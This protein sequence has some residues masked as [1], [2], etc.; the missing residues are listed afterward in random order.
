V[1]G[2]E[3][4]MYLF[5][6]KIKVPS[7]VFLLR[8]NH[9]TR[10]VNGWVA[11]YKQRCFL[12]Q[13]RC[14]FGRYGDL[15]W[16]K[17]NQVFDCLPFAATIDSSIFCVH[18]GIPPRETSLPGNRIQ[19]MLKIPVP[20]KIPFPSEHLSGAIDS[21]NEHEEGEEEEVVVVEKEVEDMSNVVNDNGYDIVMNSIQEVEEEEDA[22]VAEEEVVAA[23]EEEPSSSSSSSTSSSSSSSFAVPITQ[24][25]DDSQESLDGFDDETSSQISD[26]DEKGAFH[27]LASQATQVNAS[28]ASQ[29][30][31]PDWEE[32]EK[33]EKEEKENNMTEEELKRKEKNDLLHRTR[34]Y[35]R[36]AFNLIWADPADTN[37][38]IMMQN[39]YRHPDDDTGSD[40]GNNSSNNSRGRLQN[41]FGKGHR[42]DDSVIYG[43]NAINEFLQETGCEVSTISFNCY[44]FE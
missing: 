2:I 29:E 4:V 1:Y 25:Q 42:G 34:L 20:V 31:L 8:G 6:Y 15:I 27:S 9:E 5:A 24:P 37:Q 7:K 26:D 18:G 39:N 10:S 14:R 11:W 38:E 44:Y 40:N 23:E 36:L 13:C 33:E 43:W 22:V 30:S 35:Q 3:V 28:Q 17:V 41:G 21:E 32:E 19:Q 16:E 12:H